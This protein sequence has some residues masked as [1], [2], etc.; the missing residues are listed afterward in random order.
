MQN[1]PPFIRSETV[2]NYIKHNPAR[3]IRLGDRS[4]R[5]ERA[6]LSP[7]QVSILLNALAEPCRTL[8][9]IATLT[10]LRFGELLAPRWK[11]LDLKS[12]SVRVRETVHE[13]QFGTLRRPCRTLKFEAP[14][15]ILGFK[16]IRRSSGC[17]G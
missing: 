15:G 16:S 3:G 12:G 7:E 5:E 13:G 14:V 1:T 10:G 4:P 2:R 17:R 11:N 6:H 9:L 8:V